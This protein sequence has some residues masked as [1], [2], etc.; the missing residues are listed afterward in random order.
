[1]ANLEEA[2]DVAQRAK[3][4]QSRRAWLLLAMGVA[5]PGS[6]QLAHGSKA[7]GRLGLR[8]WLTLVVIAILAALGVWLVPGAVV[9]LIAREWV[10][11][12]LAGALLLLALFGII[13]LANT[14]W[15]ARPRQLGAARGV[16]FTLV[17]VL[18][19][20]T[21][22]FGCVTGARYLVAAGNA[23]GSILPGGGDITAKEGRYNIL[24]LGADSGP[25]RE[26]LRPDSITVA[27]VDA[28]T[29]RTVLFSLPRNLEG[30]QFAESSPLHALYPNGYQDCGED[31][32]ILNMVYLLG[33]QH[34][35]L[36]PAGVDPGV[37]AMIDVVSGTLG[38]EINYY[39]MINM[40]GFA[41]LIDAV[42]GIDITLNEAVDIGVIDD[43]NVEH[44]Y[45]T[46]G[47][48]TVH[49]DG[50]T[51]LMYARSRIQGSDYDRMARQKCVMVSMLNQL[52]PSTVAT[53]F[54][55]LA[56]AGGNLLE[57]SVPASEITTM[58]NMARMARKLPIISVSFAPPLIS[59]GNPDFAFIRQVVQDT[60]AQS[61]ALDE[62]AANP[63]PTP[64]PGG[65]E[66]DP[67]GGETTNQGNGTIPTQVD[68]LTA[69][70][71][72]A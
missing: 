63:E 3:R 14:W 65:E 54:L 61:E 30:A 35:D 60:I 38:I 67:G 62:A 44:I 52:N 39:A 26:G 23:L 50:E 40:A 21:L 69:V 5:V 70:C 13:L 25:D 6:P 29:G 2:Y 42:G 37:Q 66:T 72:A 49:M 68:D 17:T 71:S 33:L 8:V 10:L 11:V 47:P 34:A 9:W 12:G 32:C 43:W 22:A 15:L 18:L 41:A 57:T 64:T 19:A 4:V 36:Y 53:N 46:V 7:L 31:Y 51:A 24:L 56:D 16:V 45:A 59:T 20:A 28:G 55:A 1:V 58:A 48:G 27:S